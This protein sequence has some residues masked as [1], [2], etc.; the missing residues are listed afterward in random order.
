MPKVPG[1]GSDVA[2]GGS[3]RFLHHVSKVAGQ[4]DLLLPT[5]QHCRFDEQHV[6][7]G[8]RP[9]HARCHSR[10]RGPE[11][12]FPAKALLRPEILGEVFDVRLLRRR[13]GIRLRPRCH[14]CR[15]LARDRA[16]LSFEI[17]DTGLARV[18]AYHVSKRRV[19][20]LHGV[21]RE[22]VLGS[23]RGMR[24]RLAM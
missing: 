10:P 9:C 2:D 13:D 4:D 17:A 6:A 19:G 7:P 23:W 20:D 12:R 8:L 5:R 1:V 16:E 3:S 22:A 15:D 14:A 24:K 11:R 21:L 18:V